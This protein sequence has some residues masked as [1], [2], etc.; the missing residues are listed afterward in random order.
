MVSELHI[1]V[2]AKDNESITWE[3][4][5]DYKNNKI[6]FL[7]LMNLCKRLYYNKTYET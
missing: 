5:A 6:S 1:E 4:P 2:V 3:A 7:Y